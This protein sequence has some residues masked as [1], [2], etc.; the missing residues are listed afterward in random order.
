MS[1]HAWFSSHVTETNI[2]V[3]ASQRWIFP[4]CTY[5]DGRSRVFRRLRRA[6]DQLQSKSDDCSRVKEENNELEEEIKQLKENHQWVW[7]LSLRVEDIK[8][9]KNLLCLPNHWIL[10]WKAVIQTLKGTFPF[11]RAMAEAYNRRI[12]EL[13]SALKGERLER[14]EWL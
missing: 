1:I 11:L 8:W 9:W 2:K 3:Q 12:D 6:R 5:V 10:H 7:R 13:K 4:L 14:L